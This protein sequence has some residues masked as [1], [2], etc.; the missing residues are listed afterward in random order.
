[1][2]SY[3]LFQIS[4][5]LNFIFC[6]CVLGVVCYR[7]IRDWNFNLSFFLFAVILVV[8]FSIFDW[9]SYHLLHSIKI[10]YLLSTRLRIA[11]IIFYIICV[12]ITIFCTFGS[13]IMISG[14]I[15]EQRSIFHINE[16]IFLYPFL[17]FTLSSI[18]L[19]I[20]Y[21][22]LRKQINLNFTNSIENIGA[23][24]QT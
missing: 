23:G 14:M 24:N 20:S 2:K 15:K 19:C 3:K 13:I 6:L 12:L 16:Y 10:K 7:F 9:L 21:W 11:G 22:L 5:T 8:V 4:Y 1:M 18:Y 17:G